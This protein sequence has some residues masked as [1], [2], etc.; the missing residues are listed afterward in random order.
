MQY[1]FPPV[2]WHIPL[3]ERYEP[4][5]LWLDRTFSPK[6]DHWGWLRRTFRGCVAKNER[7]VV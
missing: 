5:W 2:A 3:R 4:L 6:F 1:R 7:S